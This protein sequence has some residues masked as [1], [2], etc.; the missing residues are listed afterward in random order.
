MPIDNQHHAVYPIKENYVLQRYMSLEK[1]ISLISKA[2]LFFTRLDKLEDPFEGTTPK[3]V[4]ARYIEQQKELRESGYFTVEVSDEIIE[5][6]YEEYIQLGEKFRA[7]NTVN[8]WH[9]RR[10]ENAL[11]WKAYAAN[12]N[13]IMIKS[14]Y[15]RLAR[16]F[17]KT[18]ESIQS[19]LVSYKDYETDHTIPFG[20][21][22]FLAIHKTKFYSDEN[23]LRLIYKV[24][25]DMWVHNWEEEESSYGVNIGVD[26]NALIEEIRLAPFTP[27]WY[28][29]VVKSICDKF[30]LDKKVL[31]S[32][33]EK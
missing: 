7:L 29:D 10:E 3:I 31:R 32:S 28:L 22:T 8:C 24:T 5:K 16:S 18:P 6:N 2:S 4:K 25:D 21:T 12:N 1:F 27:K 26:T 9:I 15:N 30:Q 33:L 19:S 11:M 20:N 13:G 23:E 14:D 17:E